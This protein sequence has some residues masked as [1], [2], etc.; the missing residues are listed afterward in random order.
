MQ[1]MNQ[2]KPIQSGFFLLEALI[3]I[4]VFSL[5]VLAMIALGTTAVTMQADAQYRS[6]AMNLAERISSDIWTGVVRTQV[7]VNGASMSE[8]DTVS[9]AAFQQD[10]TVTAACSFTGGDSANAAVVSWRNAIRASLPGSLPGM[11]R[12]AVNT[13]AGTGNQVTI[14]I[15]WQ[16]PSDN[17]K[18]EYTLVT[19]V[20]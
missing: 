3:G 13:A 5:G 10:Q 6:E 1:A 15:C 11:Q 2:M 14:T 4:L 20:N 18:R 17:K 9:L 7:V 16:A 12:I 19:Y 8:V